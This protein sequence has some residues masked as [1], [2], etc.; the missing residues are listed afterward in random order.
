MGAWAQAQTP[1]VVEVKPPD[2]KEHGFSSQQEMDSWAEQF[3]SEGKTKWEHIIDT[4]MAHTIDYHISWTTVQSYLRQK[5]L[6]DYTIYHTVRHFYENGKCFR[7]DTYQIFQ[8][9]ELY[10]YAEY[11]GFITVEEAHAIQV[12]KRLDELSWNLYFDAVYNLINQEYGQFILEN[13]DSTDV[14]V[15]QGRYGLP[16]A[17]LLERLFYQ[18]LSIEEF[19]ANVDFIQTYWSRLIQEHDIS[20]KRHGEEI[21]PVYDVKLLSRG[22]ANVDT[23]VTK[24]EIPCNRTV[25]NA[26]EEMHLVNDDWFGE[27]YRRYQEDGDPIFLEE[28]LISLP[29]EFHPWP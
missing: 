1:R 4:E 29:W 17:Q 20:L 6:D 12:S 5:M 26:T 15:A 9:Y 10:R 13:F 19:Q 16:N 25:V 7:E 23:H 2:P 8:A 22:Q 24:V 11:K 18:Q 21:G 27:M 3:E 28:I 14:S